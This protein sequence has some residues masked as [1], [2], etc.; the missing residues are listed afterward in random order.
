VKP[1][2]AAFNWPRF[3]KFA[4]AASTQT[5]FSYYCHQPSAP[6]CIFFIDCQQIGI[7]KPQVLEEPAV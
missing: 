3:G 5:V 2:G 1:R 6:I 4:F 7:K